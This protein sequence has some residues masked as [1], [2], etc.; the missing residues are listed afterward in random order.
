[1]IVSPDDIIGETPWSP[2]VAREAW[3]D[4]A[5]IWETSLQSGQFNRAIIM[6]GLPGSGKSTAARKMDDDHTLILDSTMTVSARRDEYAA[7]CGHY[8]VP[9][10]FV[11]CDASADTCKARQ[12]GRRFPVPFDV[13]DRM[14]S[15]LEASPVVFRGVPIHRVGN[16]Y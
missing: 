8:N 1:M 12:K 6:V 2:A 5:H 3:Q 4:T 10:C 13:I 16:G 14:A 9:V 11:Y 7:I 15:Q